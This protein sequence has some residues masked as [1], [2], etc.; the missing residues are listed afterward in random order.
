MNYVHTLG[1]YYKDIYGWETIEDDGSFIAYYIDKDSLMIC[2]FYVPEEDR[3]KGKAIK[4]INKAVDVAKKSY[5]SKICAKVELKKRGKKTVNPS[6]SLKVIL[7]HGFIPY[8]AHNDEVYVVRN[9]IKFT[10]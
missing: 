9:I 6:L 2:E 10:N 5:C 8:G 1:R 3:K 7:G 4:L